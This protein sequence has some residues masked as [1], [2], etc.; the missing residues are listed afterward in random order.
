[1]EPVTRGKERH[2]IRVSDELWAEFG[3]VAEPNRTAVLVAYMRRYIAAKGG[4]VPDEPKLKPGPKPKPAD[5]ME[6]VITNHGDKP[7]EG[8]RVE[9][10]HRP[11]SS[12]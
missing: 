12:G 2:A 10:R 9:I 7:A 3:R 8:M 4:T 5:Q 11:A 1:M 6:L